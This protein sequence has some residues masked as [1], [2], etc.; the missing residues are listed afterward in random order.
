LSSAPP[1]F[2]PALRHEVRA[3][4]QQLYLSLGTRGPAYSDPDRYP[5]IMLNTLLGGGMSSRL[6]QSVREEAGLAYSIYSAA[7]FHRD[8]GLISIQLGVS[9]ERGREALARVREELS[10]LCESGP[11]PDE[12]EAAR[13]Q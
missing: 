4:L 10:V 3:E 9:P 13:N 8:S 6:F 1:P 11:S 5:L 12:I 2:I 7:D